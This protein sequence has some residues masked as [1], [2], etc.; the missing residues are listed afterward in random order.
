MG[1]VMGAFLRIRRN[2]ILV[3]GGHREGSAIAEGKGLQLVQACRGPPGKLPAQQFDPLKAKAR[4]VLD[5]ALQRILLPF[6]VPIRVGGDREADAGGW[7][8]ALRGSRGGSGGSERGSAQRK[9]VASGEC[10]GS[11]PWL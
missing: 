3:D 9:A 8:G 5:D 7:L 1:D 11:L 2:E 4:G 6:E 10:H